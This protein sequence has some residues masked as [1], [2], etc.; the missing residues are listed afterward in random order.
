MALAEEVEVTDAEVN[1]F[2]LS[3]QYKNKCFAGLFST[4]VLS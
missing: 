1:W 2:Y 3:V 4:M